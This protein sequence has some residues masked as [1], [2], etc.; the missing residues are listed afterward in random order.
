MFSQ[1]KLSVKAPE[2]FMSLSVRDSLVY[3][4]V[5]FCACMKWCQGH[6]GS[7]STVLK[8]ILHRLMLILQRRRASS[9]AVPAKLSP[10][11][12]PKIHLL[13]VSLHHLPK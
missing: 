9:D 6:T 10:N 8:K 1:L 3:E 12:L 4:K 13:L 7:I 2:A 5:L 11:S